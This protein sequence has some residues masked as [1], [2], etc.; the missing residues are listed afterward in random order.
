MSHLSRAISTRSRV[1]L[2][3]AITATSLAV[4]ALLIGIVPDRNS[5]VRQGR[6]ELCESIALSTSL[7]ATRGRATDVNALLEAVVQ[8]ND[9]VLSAALRRANRSST[10]EVGD[11][12]AHWKDSESTDTQVRV[13]IYAGQEKWGTVEV[14]FRPLTLSGWKGVFAQP[15]FRLLVFVFSAAFLLFY[16]YLGRVLR[17]LDPSKVVPQRVRSALDNL[18]EGLLVL[19]RREQ[20]LLANKAFASLLGKDPDQL[21]GLRASKLNWSRPD[22]DDVS[23]AMPWIRA[24]EQEAPLPN[25]MLHLDLADLGRRTFVVNSSPLLGHDGTYRG[26]LVSLDDVTQLEEKKIEL[27]KSKAAAEAASK[28]KSEFLAN[29]SHEIRTPMNAILGFTEVLRRNMVPTEA[30]RRRHLSTIHSSGTHLLELINDVLDL[31]KIEA[32]RLEIERQDCSP[33]QIIHAL[34]A[35]FRIRAEEKK[36]SLVYRAEGKTP[37]T[38]LSDAAR[39]RQTLT[40]LVGNA[41]KFTQQGGVEIVSR[42]LVQDGRTW[43]AVDVIDTGIGMTEEA[44]QVVFDPFVQADASVTRRFGGTGLGLAI[45]RRFAKAL[46]G[47]LAVRSAPGQGSTFTFTVDTG[48]LHDVKMLQPSDVLQCGV[49]NEPLEVTTAQ[50]PAARILVVDDGI[51]NRELATL[52]LR[53]AGATVD[54]AENGEVAI[55]RVGQQRYDVVLM[56]MQM[57][58][59]DGYTATRQLRQ[60]GLSVPIIAMTAHALAGD[61]Q[62]CR[63]AGCSGFLTKPIDIDELLC[64]VGDGLVTCGKRRA[65]P[66]PP[67]PPRSEP[68]VGDQPITSRLASDPRF[69]EIIRSFQPRLHDQ[70]EAMEAAWESRD[71]AELTTLA[72]WLKGSGGTVGFDAF[73]APAAELE[74]MARE[75]RD[76]NM[77]ETIQ[78]IRHITELLVIPEP[79]DEPVAS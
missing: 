66:T 25:V 32:G 10:I 39:F 77:A 56:D 57:P 47:D 76:D 68:T 61:E 29:M 43:L 18:A 52:V 69:H 37:E 65:E 4:V 53:E 45:S 26:V 15:W 79:A 27:G 78:H 40:N 41:I 9:Q 2:G 12:V 74:R 58:V 46:G 22:G 3:L 28:A 23:Q 54:S 1:T 55:E 19:D 30:E 35:M 62:K 63:D 75:R 49:E 70:L 42:L 14:R 16:V 5:A 72:H 8:R 73:T 33:H 6:A 20:I 13:P 17:Q 60:S 44:A 51:E 50:L 31:S 36:I 11:H 34:V 64:V 21:M 24:M 7:L 48:P 71:F 38:I 67:S 59:M